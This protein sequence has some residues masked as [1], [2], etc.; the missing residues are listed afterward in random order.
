[1]S[2]KPSIYGSSNNSEK[3][4][5]LPIVGVDG[6]K[7]CPACKGY[8]SRTKTPPRCPECLQEIDRSEAD[9]EADSEAKNA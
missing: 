2:K 4:A 7:Y 3:P 5:A 1:M 9:S 6:R 8:L